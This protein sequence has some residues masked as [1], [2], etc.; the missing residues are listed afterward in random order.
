MSTVN[1]L[2]ISKNVGGLVNASETQVLTDDEGVVANPSV[3]AAQ[4]GVLTVRTDNN[5][6]SLT[7]T[8]SGHGIVTGQRI[9]LFWAGGAR[10]GMTVGTVAGLVVP[11]DLGSGSNLPSAAAAIVVGIATDTGFGI[12]GDNL[13]ALLLN[14]GTGPVRAYFVFAAAGT[15]IA[16]IEITAAGVLYTWYT[17]NGAVNPLAGLTPDKV[18]MSH[19]Y[20]TGAVTDM[21]TA[22][23][24]H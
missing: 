5:T 4:P 21:V 18:W 24:T 16:V 13:T 20:E 14:P 6:G 17:G 2:T 22:A 9:D 3:P 10:Y 11:I 1:Q 15:D 8:N 7:M 23:L 12:T 19:D